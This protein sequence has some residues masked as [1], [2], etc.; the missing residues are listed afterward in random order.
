MCGMNIIVVSRVT[1]Y[2]E[3]I[4]GSRISETLDIAKFGSNKIDDNF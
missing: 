4:M 1:I 2:F 3:R